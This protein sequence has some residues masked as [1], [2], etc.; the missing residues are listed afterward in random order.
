MGLLSEADCRECELIRK[1]R[2][3][4][5]HQ[6][7]VSLKTEKVVSICAQL[8]FSAKRYDEVHIDTRGQFTSAVVALI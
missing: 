3:G 8:Q 6:I 7:K 1:P 5:A 4:F 2:N